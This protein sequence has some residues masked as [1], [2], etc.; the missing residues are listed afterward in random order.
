MSIWSDT[1]TTTGDCQKLRVHG[2]ALLEP[3][4]QYLLGAL[5]LKIE[6]NCRTSVLSHLGQAGGCCFKRSCSLIG[7]LTSKRLPQPLHSN[8]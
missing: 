5:V 6:T 8:S 3:P 1:A 4:A 7:T 2:G